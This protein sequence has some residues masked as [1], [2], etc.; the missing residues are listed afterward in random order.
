[1]T[2][3]VERPMREQCVQR[4]AFPAMGN[5][6]LIVAV[7]DEVQVARHALEVARRR[8]AELESRWS[9]FLPESDI[10]RFNATG[11]HR[12]LGA[13]AQLLL[14][15]MSQANIA[16]DGLFDAGVLPQVLRLGYDRSL[17]DGR[18]AIPGGHLGAVDPGGIGKG[19]AA[20]L[21]VD[22]M[23]AVECSGALVSIGGDLR[24]AGSADH[25]DGWVIDVESPKSSDQVGRITLTS[26]GVATSSLHA[27]RWAILASSESHVVDPHSRRS[28]DP[29]TRDVVQATVV[30]S[31]AA[32]AEA[33]ATACLVADAAAAVAMIDRA[34]LAALLVRSDGSTIATTGWKDFA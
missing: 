30:A 2:I 19:L 20:D 11:D 22:G 12:V 7:A 28:L 9:R 3:D 15:H 10:S 31:T 4:E 26:G 24:C 34:G 8:L 27:K 14:D 16:T 29:N 6:A 13:D 17:V 18:R 21:V 32:W 1:M 5:T 33:F 23:L 25:G